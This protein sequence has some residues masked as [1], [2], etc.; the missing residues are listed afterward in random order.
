MANDADDDA[1]FEAEMNARM[2]RLRGGET[3]NAP[4]KQ[5]E[6]KEAEAKLMHYIRFGD[7]QRSDA[8]QVEDL[9]SYMGESIELGR[10]AV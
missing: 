10:T 2:A 6:S 8:D 3:N 1:A 9:L 4:M 5:Q 7:G